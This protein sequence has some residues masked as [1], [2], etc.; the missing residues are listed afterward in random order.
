MGRLHE[1]RWR[2]RGKRGPKALTE[3]LFCPFALSANP[4]LLPFIVTICLA[5]TKSSLLC[6]F[7]RDWLVL[8]CTFHVRVYFP[9]TTLWAKSIP[10]RDSKHDLQQSI[11]FLDSWKSVSCHKNL[12]QRQ[13]RPYPRTRGDQSPSSLWNS[14]F[15]Y[16]LIT[17]VSKTQLCGKLILP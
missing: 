8:N 13:A 15:Q 17:E 3:C 12:K 6:C 7:D 11:D 1:R 4:K 16:A 10:V 5:S 9:V 14:H 2:S